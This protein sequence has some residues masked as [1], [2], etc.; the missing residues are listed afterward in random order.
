MEMPSRKVK[1]ETEGEL[2]RILKKIEK[3]QSDDIRELF[4]VSRISKE[5]FI[6]GILEFP[7]SEQKELVHDM[8][9]HNVLDFM[10]HD[11]LGSWEQMQ[12]ASR[13]SVLETVYD[14]LDIESKTVG[15]KAKGK[16]GGDRK[17]AIKAWVLRL[18]NLY[19]ETVTN[20][21]KFEELQINTNETISDF[22][23]VAQGLVDKV[24]QLEKARVGK[25]A[26]LV[27]KICG[28]EEK[29]NILCKLSM[30]NQEALLKVANKV[31]ESAAER[32]I[33][34]NKDISYQEVT[35]KD[36]RE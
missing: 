30:V 28:L 3:V 31:A 5:D 16:M 10:L 17:E 20:S 12:R 14:V 18:I 34:E 22:K 32:H 2:E 7:K 33:L 4:K 1:F 26:E 15:K 23:N 11:K 27:S 21:A 24:D 25:E 9:Q 8:L 35:G 36:R 29:L 6:N 19:R 13:F